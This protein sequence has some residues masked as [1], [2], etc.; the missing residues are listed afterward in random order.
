MRRST[1]YVYVGAVAALAVAA[2]RDIG[3]EPNGSTKPSSASIAPSFS[4]TRANQDRTVIGSLSITPGGGTYH[5]G[6][7]DIVIPAGAVCDPTTTKYGPRHWNDDCAPANRTITVNVV[8]VRRHGN[9]SIDFQPDL[10]FRP[11]AGWAR[12]E[13]RAY[14]DLLTSDAIR[15]LSPSSPYFNQFLLLYA[16]S[17]QAARIDEVKSLSDPSLVTH[18][19]RST[20]VLWRRVKHFSGYIIAGFKCD[21]STDAGD[22][23]CSGDPTGGVGAIASLVSDSTSMMISVVVTP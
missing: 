20:G 21:A 11:K 3:V 12:I 17:G 16:P 9:V 22:V 4:K 10:R 7:F 18:I 1:I 15:Q 6:D 5:V 19:D 14:S 23:Q 2:C 13:T 8:S